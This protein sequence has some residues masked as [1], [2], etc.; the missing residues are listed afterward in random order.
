VSGNWPNIRPSTR[1]NDC[2]NEKLDSIRL[3]SEFIITNIPSQKYSIIRSHPT[4]KAANINKAVRGTHTRE[5]PSIKATAFKK[6][7][8]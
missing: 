5:A 8:I 7:S 3:K 2:P 4:Q 6:L 1:E